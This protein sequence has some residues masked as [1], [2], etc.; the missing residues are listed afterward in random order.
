MI[1]FDKDKEKVLLFVK[2]LLYKNYYAKNYY[3][4]IKMLL[5]AYLIGDVSRTDTGITS[6]CILWWLYN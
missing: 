6:K 3:C 5:C 4:E 2:K 1:N